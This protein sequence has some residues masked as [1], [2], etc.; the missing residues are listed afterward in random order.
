M[1]VTEHITVMGKK[2]GCHF[3]VNGEKLTFKFNLFSDLLLKTFWVENVK[4]RNV[5][6]RFHRVLIDRNILKLKWF[7]C[8]RNVEVCRDKGW[9]EQCAVCTNSWQE[10]R[11]HHMHNIYLVE[12]Q[13]QVGAQMGAQAGVRARVQV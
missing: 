6:N 13:E 2:I 11:C 7:D 1:A 3:C 8:L 4:L 5:K 12:Q 9:E 10:M